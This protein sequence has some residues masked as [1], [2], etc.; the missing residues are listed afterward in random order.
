MRSPSP[1]AHQGGNEAQRTGC[2]RGSCGG[3]IWAPAWCLSF[4]QES[5]VSG[6]QMP[7]VLTLSCKGLVLACLKGVAVLLVHAGSGRLCVTSDQ[8]GV[9]PLPRESESTST[10]PWDPGAQMHSR[11]LPC[12]WWG[13]GPA[14]ETSLVSSASVPWLTDKQQGQASAAPSGEIQHK[15]QPLSAKEEASLLP[16]LRCLLLQSIFQLLHSP[17]PEVTGLLLNHALRIALIG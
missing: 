5:S 11:V 12:G 10:T 1:A 17:K 16:W 9:S 2:C 3:R 6:S 14:R 15:P 7:A 8:D 13:A 4:V